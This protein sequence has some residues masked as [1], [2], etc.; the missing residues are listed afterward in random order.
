MFSFSMFKE[1]EFVKFKQ[2]I[3][4][5]A[6]TMNYHDID[7]TDDELVQLSWHMGNSGITPEARGEDIVDKLHF[8]IKRSLARRYSF[9][10]LLRGDPAAYEEFVQAQNKSAILPF[11]VFKALS[12]EAKALDENIQADIK[13]SCFLTISDKAKEALKSAGHVLSTD[14]EEFLSQ[15]ASLARENNSIFPLTKNLNRE[16]LNLL[17]K[18]Y[19]PNMHFRHM[20]YTEGGDNMSKTFSDGVVKGDFGKQDFLAW[21]W[22]WLTNI[23]GF[24]G[25]QGAKYYDAQTHFLTAAVIAEL[26]RVLADPTYSY[27]DHYLLKRAELAGLSDAPFNLSETEQQLLGHLAAYCNQ[28]N[29]LTP[30]L[31]KMIYAGYAA[32]KEEF[33][34]AGELAALYESQR[35]DKAAVTPTYV[36]AIINNAYLTFKNKFKMDEADSLKNASQFMCQLLSKLLAFPHDKRISCMNLAKETSMQAILEK[37]ISN[38]HAFDFKLN[39][40][41]ELMAEELPKL[42]QAFNFF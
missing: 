34:D 19:W 31:G 17:P 15:L 29:V 3:K 42:N 32:F 24:Q 20:L 6:E 41:V 30:D 7:I 4:K 27:L 38:H 8:E 13:A 11:T 26:E 23:F 16:Q 5:Y 35:K 40:N 22:R 36:P 18:V 1:D 37:W 9:E 33:D 2:A 21:K 39:D 12:E 14:S 28:V 10:L 25:G